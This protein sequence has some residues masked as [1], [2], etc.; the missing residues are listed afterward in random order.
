VWSLAQSSGELQNLDPAAAALAEYMWL[1][2]DRDPGWVA[3]IQAILERGIR[4]G[5]V[6][7]SGALAFWM[8]KLGLLPTTPPRLFPL[9]RS[10]I[11]GNATTAAAEW[12]AR[13]CPYEYGLALTEGDHAARKQAVRTFEDLGATAAASRVRA[14]LAAVG[15]RVPRG[16]SQS[17]RA[18]VAGLT[19]RQAEVLDLLALGLSNTEV[20]E[21]LFVSHRTIE[22]HVAAILM[23]LDAPTRHAAVVAARER[24]LLSHPEPTAQN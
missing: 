1:A 22:N 4:S 13:G 21:R 8:W 20:A 16:P 17:T 9:Y 11:E 18:H 15:I 14:E 19:A 2:G 24:G 3:R 5:F 23:K 12:Q 10:I 6:W 7:P